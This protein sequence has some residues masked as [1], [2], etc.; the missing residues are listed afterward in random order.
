MDVVRVGRVKL[1]ARQDSGRNECLVQEKRRGEEREKRDHEGL[2]DAV[3]SKVYGQVCLRYFNLRPLYARR[4]P[5]SG[6]TCGVQTR[7]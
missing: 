4:D 7:I 2:G 1:G 5:S 6:R 3:P